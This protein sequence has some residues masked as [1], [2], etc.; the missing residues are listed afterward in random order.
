MFRTPRSDREDSLEQR[1]EQSKTAVR[2]LV[3]SFGERIEE[4]G[5]GRKELEDDKKRSQ[6]NFLTTC[7]QLEMF[8]RSLSETSEAVFEKN[9]T[10]AANAMKMVFG[11]YDHYIK[12]TSDFERVLP[13]IAD[14]DNLQAL[15][16]KYLEGWNT[17]LD[18]MGE[19]SETTRMDALRALLR[20]KK[21]EE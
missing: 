19:A 2:S 8:S 5:K 10:E 11:V 7:S 1:I 4:L 3:K 16:S 17:I 9:P 21:L 14:Y 13:G 18:K 12:N 15:T 6:I 20:K